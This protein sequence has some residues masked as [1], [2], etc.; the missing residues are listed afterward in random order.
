MKLPRWPVG[1]EGRLAPRIGRLAVGALLLLGLL[2]G[3]AWWLGPLWLRAAVQTQGSAALGREV[4]LEEVRLR[5]WSLELELRGLRVAGPVPDAPPLLQV[6][7]V[8]A[9]LELQSVFRLAPIVDALQVQ[10]PRVNLRHLGDG[11]YD[12]DDLI[13]RLAQ[14]PQGGEPFRFG[15]FNLALTQGELHLEDAAAGATHELRELSVSIPFLSN[16]PAQRQVRTEP[17][18][19]FVLNGSHFDSRL[20]TLPFA[21]STATQAQLRVPDLDLAPYLAYWPKALPIRPR[22]AHVSADL[23]LAFEQG[24]TPFVQL[25]GELALRDVRVTQA[26]AGAASRPLLEWDELALTLADVRPL[27]RKLHFGRIAWRAPSVQLLRGADGQLDTVAL[28]AAQPAGG[29]TAKPPASPAPA[30]QPW[31]VQV[32][33]L[34]LQ[35]GK[36]SWRD[37]TLQPAWDTR[38]DALDLTARGLRWPSDTPA[39]LEASARWGQATLGV[40]GQAGPDRAELALRW[41]DLALGDLAPP[42]APLLSVP[43]AGRSQGE[44]ALHWLAAGAEGTTPRLALDLKDVAVR[45]LALGPPKAPVAGW[46]ELRVQDGQVDLLGR[47]ADLGQLSLLAPRLALARDPAGR[48]MWS[49]WLADS[50]LPGGEAPPASGAQAAPWRLAWKGLRLDEGAGALHDA[51]TATPVALNWNGLRLR[52]GPWR[53]DAATDVPLLLEA[54]LAGEGRAA[55]PGTLALEGRLGLAPLATGQGGGTR[56]NARLR[57]GRLPAHLL[58]PYLADRLQIV[59]QRAELGGQLGLALQVS[60]AGLDLAVDGDLAVEELRALDASASEPLLNW[61]TLNLRGLRLALAPGQPTRVQVAETVLSDYF[62]RIDID[63]SGRIN[64]QDLVRDPAPTSAALPAAAPATASAPARLSFGPIS[65]VRGDIAFSDRFVRPNYSARLSEVTGGLGAFSNQGDTASAP[66]QLSLRG[67]VEGTGSLELQG[68]L[69]PLLTRPVMDLR[70]QVR[71]LEL[72]PLSTYALKYVGH[73]IERGQ[74]SVDVR[75]QIDGQGRLNASNQLTLNRL[76][77]GER[78]AASE[79]PNLPVRLAVALLADRNGVI[80]INLPISGSLNDPEFRLGPLIGR[81]ILGL[82]GKAVTAPFALIGQLLGGGDAENGQVDF[83]AGTVRLAPGADARLAAVAKALQDRPALQVAVVGHS[84]PASEREALQRERLQEA[85][86]AEKRRQMLRGGQ[87]AEAEAP[88]VSAQEYPALLRELYRRADWPRP[89]NAIGMLKDL[90][91]PEMES[92]WLAHTPLPEG[93]LVDLAQRRALAVKAGLVGQGLAGSRV[94]VEAPKAG[95]QPG[96]RAE[97]QLS[98][99]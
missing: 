9:D 99:H 97:L 72:P 34:A 91:V 19:A 74:L 48:W 5:P 13:E 65:L 46:R 95:A 10:R 35:G 84:D 62:A 41:N 52:L 53:S 20:S 94:F 16:L 18:V 47:S 80:D 77:F 92:L 42:L 59:L 71:E 15:L 50:P 25:Q 33:E 14:R 63:P 83:V 93:A 67:R 61:K 70:G 76:V 39:T 82:I 78:D 86:R 22:Q 98:A 66:A 55:V 60:D 26:A 6:E 73:G 21:E 30:P 37:G 23:K 57:L 75:Y 58:M 24:Q 29:D 12:I 1:T 49:G 88:E 4:R 2:W 87:G 96:A 38:L 68:Q 79:A 43:L 31:S 89:R 3:L 8:Y 54:S 28:F 11:H 44:V 7:R 56:L 90:P 45:E 36:L 51:A 40:S 64:L 27:E 17:H 32:D 69:Q 85:V 81:L